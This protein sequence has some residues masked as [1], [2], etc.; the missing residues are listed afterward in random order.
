M[1]INLI[2]QK[3]LE[4]NWCVLY[5]YPNYEKKVL[6]TATQ[7]NIICF[8]PTHKVVRQW[9]D[10]KKT[11]EVPLFPNYLFVH[12]NRQNRF[13]ILDILGVTHFVSHCGK[14]A[15]ISPQEIDLIRKMT[16]EREVSLER[17]FLKGDLVKI[18]DGPF[19]GLE[20]ILFE[21]KGNSRFAVKIEGINQSISISI[22]KSAVLK[23]KKKQYT[24]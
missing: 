15:I 19:S 21:K 8:L 14:P 22:N 7:K 20:G 5:T 3:C 13:E 6:R 16:A 18:V 24:S 1:S 12:T 17:D 9:S 4:S 2:Q 23:I 11:I 10:R